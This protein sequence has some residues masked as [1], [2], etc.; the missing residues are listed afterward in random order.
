MITHE[1]PSSQDEGI[2]KDD[3]ASIIKRAKFGNNQEES[4]PFVVASG[5]LKQFGDIECYNL[6]NGQRVFRLSNM[7]LALRG[8]AHGKFANYLSTSNLRQFLPERLW[9]DKEKDRKAQGVTWAKFGSERIPTYDADDFID[10]CT[11]FTDLIDSGQDYSEVQKEIGQRAKQFIRATA[12][13]GISA[14][15][16]EATGY[17]YARPDDALQTKLQF[18]LADSLQPWEKTFPDALWQQF[19]RLTEWKGS[20][21]RRPKYWGKLVNEFIY[22]YLDKD[23]AIWLRENVPPKLTGQKYH[24]WLKQEVK[25]QKLNSHIN[26]IIGIAMTCKNIN[27]LRIKARELFSGDIMNPLF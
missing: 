13:I 25:V 18:L 14:L 4:I 15:I 26:Q 21:H 10:I 16:D 19:G 8:K 23:L 2:S 22:N 5:F 17:Q 9:P 1:D 24:Q 6:N 11:A 27:E 20:L 12:K 3:F 7:T